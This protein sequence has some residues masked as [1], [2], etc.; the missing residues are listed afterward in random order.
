M[1]FTQMIKV[2]CKQPEALIEL[3]VEWDQQQA[4][5]DIMGYIG[6]RMLA[7]QDEPDCFVII[8]DFAEVDDERSS[9]EEAEYNNSRQ[10]TENWAMR[11]R[12][13]V[14]GEPEWVHFD[15]LYYTGIT[16]N[17]RTG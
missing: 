15:E 13:L 7:S 4:T 2:R 10:E 17:L 12:E 3:L 14:E 8:A 9:S 11:M 6:T 16:G 1:K 5:T